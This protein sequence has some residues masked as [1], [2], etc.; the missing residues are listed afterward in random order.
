[1]KVD[2][3]VH[4]EEGP[5]SLDW[6]V[7][8]ACALRPFLDEKEESESRGWANELVKGLAQRLQSGPYS[9]EWLDLYRA[10]AKQAGIVQV[11]V[12]EHLYRFAEYRPYYERYVRVGDDRLGRAQRRW[13]AQMAND[14]LPAYVAFLAE[15]RERW[16][17]DGLAL[18]IG[19]ELD[20]FPGGEDVLREVSGQYPWDVCMGAVHF[21][22]GWGFPVRDVQEHWER[23]APAGLYSSYFD[24]LE[25]AIESGLFDVMVHLDGIKAFGPKPDETALLP[26]YQRI[27]RALRRKDMAAELNAGYVRGQ[28]LRE[29]S[30]S[31][32]FLQILAQHEVPITLS[33]HATA[34]DQVGQHL[35]EARAQLKRAGFAAVAVFADRKRS[36]L[37][38]G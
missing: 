17:E 24:V 25:Q 19:I 34:P 28:S 12:A 38:I 14:S 21:P 8:Q 1:M 20:Y 5:Y 7:G 35:A 27:A 3:H 4:L 22:G 36:E 18:R 13:L 15:E 26:Y 31:F 10:R 37:A 9:R 6:L 16:A 2:F 29:F 32:R 33:S 11:C 30:P 23:V